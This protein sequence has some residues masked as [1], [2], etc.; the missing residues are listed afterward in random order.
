MPVLTGIVR[1]VVMVAFG[2]S[3]YMPAECLGPAGLDG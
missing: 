3:S 1:D 2:A